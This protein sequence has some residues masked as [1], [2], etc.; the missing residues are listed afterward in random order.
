MFAVLPKYIL[1]GKLLNQLRGR[2]LFTHKAAA[3]SF[4]G[5]ILQSRRSVGDRLAA[6]YPFACQRKG[7]TYQGLP[8]HLIHQTSEPETDPVLFKRWLP[9]VRDSGRGTGAREAAAPTSLATS[10]RARLGA[11]SATAARQR[12]PAAAAS[13]STA[14]LRLRA[15]W[16]RWRCRPGAAA[17]P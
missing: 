11:S 2:S 10:G 5:H 4:T 14:T 17:P 16:R 9:L 1:S 12:A 3:C 13:P 8:A 15:M 7:N 6:E